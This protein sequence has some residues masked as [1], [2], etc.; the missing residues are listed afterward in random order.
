MFLLGCGDNL[1]KPPVVRSRTPLALAIPWNQL[2]QT[3]PLIIAKLV[4]IHD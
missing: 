2:L 3:F 4:A 1:E